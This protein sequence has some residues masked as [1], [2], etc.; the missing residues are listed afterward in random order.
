MNDEGLF[1]KHTP[2]QQK[3]KKMLVDAFEGCVESIY[4]DVPSDERMQFTLAT[5]LLCGFFE[6]MFA[7]VIVA[8][9][10]EDQAPELVDDLT[11]FLIRNTLAK[12]IIKFKESYDEEKKSK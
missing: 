8:Y 7:N 10:M 11:K 12:V 3:N 4:K 2:L 9:K 1:E 5:S 6:E